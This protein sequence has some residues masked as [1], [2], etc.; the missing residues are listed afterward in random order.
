MLDKRFLFSLSSTTDTQIGRIESFLRYD[1]ENSIKSATRK[2]SHPILTNKF[3]L[4]DGK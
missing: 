2:S 3:I 1:S 4:R